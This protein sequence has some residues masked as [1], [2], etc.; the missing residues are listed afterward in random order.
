MMSI[1]DVVKSWDQEERTADGLI[2]MLENRKDGFSCFWCKHLRKDGISCD[3]FPE[4]I[5]DIIIN[6]EHDHRT[7]F[8][9]DN[10]ILFEPKE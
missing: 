10:G 6:G 4:V 9:G 3:A 7:P 1:K 5:P 8:S 2:K